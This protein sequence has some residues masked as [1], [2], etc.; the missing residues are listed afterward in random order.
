MFGLFFF[1]SYVASYVG[2]IQTGFLVTFLSRLQR[3][4]N[5]D[6][7]EKNSTGTEKT[8]NQRIPA[9]ITNLGLCLM[10]PPPLPLCCHQPLVGAQQTACADVAGL[11]SAFV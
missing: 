5:H 3:K 9:G 10:S 6:S 8:G 2:P 1:K 7:C 11:L 4:R